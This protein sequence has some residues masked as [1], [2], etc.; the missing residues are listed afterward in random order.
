M[1]KLWLVT[2][3]VNTYYDTYDSMVV[4]APTEEVARNTHPLEAYISPEQWE[5]EHHDPRFPT[6]ASFVDN[7]WKD[8]RSGWA[9]SPKDV[10][11]TLLGTADRRIKPGIVL[12]SF[13]AG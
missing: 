2:Q 10:K 4:C 6:Y 1:N 7:A 5:T 11:V 9:N 13:N 12:A 3:D 8:K